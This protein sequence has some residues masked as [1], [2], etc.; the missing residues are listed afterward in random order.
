MSW[1][2]C[3]LRQ[4]LGVRYQQPW[5]AQ[6]IEV[7]QAQAINSHGDAGTDAPAVGGDADSS[8]AIP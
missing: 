6:F 4:L 5:P 2:V 7:D 3:W 8:D 1:R